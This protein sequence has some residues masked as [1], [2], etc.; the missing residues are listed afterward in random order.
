MN[1]IKVLWFLFANNIFK[2]EQERIEHNLEEINLIKKV[3][4]QLQL[5]KMI[6]ILDNNKIP[7]EHK[8]NLLQNSD[9]PAL[10]EMIVENARIF[11]KIQR[12]KLWFGHNGID[13]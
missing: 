2:N 5:Q 10:Q 12:T 3:H 4:Y 13:F 8:L 6:K 11:N 9:C 1:L 7:A